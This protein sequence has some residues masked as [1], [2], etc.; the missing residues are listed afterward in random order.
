M[1]ILSH[2][3]WFDYLQNICWGHKAL[4]YVV[5]STPC[6]LI[7]LIPNILR[8]SLVSNNPQPT[9]LPQSERPSFTPIQINR[10]RLI[11]ESFKILVH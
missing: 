11:T 6:Y 10:Q 3:S 8:S 5:F 2:S 4:H 9:L 7:P 1:P